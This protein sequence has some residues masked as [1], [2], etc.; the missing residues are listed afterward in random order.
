MAKLVYQTL[1]VTTELD[2]ALGSEANAD[3]TSYLG[4]DPLRFLGTPVTAPAGDAYGRSGNARWAGDDP[5]GR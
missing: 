5:M 4:P 2:R 3:G 1:G